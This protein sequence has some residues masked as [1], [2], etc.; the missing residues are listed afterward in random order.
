MDC[1]VTAIDR[2][3]ILSRFH[4]TEGFFYPHEGV[5]ILRAVEEATSG[6]TG[7]NIVE[8]GNWVGKST[9]ILGSV[10]KKRG[11]RV[12]AIDPHE[13]RLSIPG[14]GEE[15]W[16]SSLDGFRNTISKYELSDVVIPIMARSESIPWNLPIGFL[17]IDALHDYKSVQADILKYVPWVDPDGLIMFHDYDLP[18]FPGCFNAVNDAIAAGMFHK[19]RLDGVLFVGRKL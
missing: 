17:F 1:S 15:T 3:E 19:E 7:G 11:W 10:A 4:A 9:V 12:Y 5:A 13:G 16:H 2:D 6:K 18:Q 8:I 14:G